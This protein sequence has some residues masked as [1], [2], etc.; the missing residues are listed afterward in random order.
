M[1]TDYLQDNFNAT[2]DFDKTK[3]VVEIKLERNVDTYSTGEINLILFITKLF[4]F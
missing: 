3:K 4:S 2:V 1:Y